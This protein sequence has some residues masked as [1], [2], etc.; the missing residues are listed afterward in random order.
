MRANAQ[1]AATISYV[2][3]FSFGGRERAPAKDD[4]V[5]SYSW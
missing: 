4:D 5:V 1:W 2:C 3:V